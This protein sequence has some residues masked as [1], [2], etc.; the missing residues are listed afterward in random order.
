MAVYNDPLIERPLI[1]IVY[2][3][4][5]VEVVKKHNVYVYRFIKSGQIDDVFLGNVIQLG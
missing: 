5:L 1:Y 3:I 2:F 4:H